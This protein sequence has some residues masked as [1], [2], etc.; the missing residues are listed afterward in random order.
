[1]KNDLIQLVTKYPGDVKHL[2][3]GS[4]TDGWIGN[5]LGFKFEG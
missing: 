4:I 1:V 5:R 2:E 3:V